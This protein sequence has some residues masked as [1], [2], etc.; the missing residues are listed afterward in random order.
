MHGSPTGNSG[1]QLTT[2]VGWQAMLACVNVY[3]QEIKMFDQEENRIA[4][5]SKV[6]ANMWPFK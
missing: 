4:H 2:M 6:L 1:W 3:Y 5:K